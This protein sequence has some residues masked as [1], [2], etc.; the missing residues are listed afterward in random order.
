MI[1]KQEKEN[2]DLATLLEQSEHDTENNQGKFG[3][4]RSKVEG[5]DNKK[6]KKKLL[7]KLKK[8]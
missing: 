6:D 2:K 3:L 4:N 1:A 8:T 5:R 7:E